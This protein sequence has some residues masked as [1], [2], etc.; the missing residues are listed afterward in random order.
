MQIIISSSLLMTAFMG[1]EIETEIEFGPDLGQNYGTI[2]EARDDSG[3]LRIGAGFV[4]VYNTRYRSDRQTLQF[5]VRPAANDP[6]EIFE[7]D[8]LPRPSEAAGSYLFDF[9]GKLHSR[10]YIADSAMRVWDPATQTWGID[11]D[12][13]KPNEDRGDQKMTVAG[14]MLWFDS[15]SVKYDGEEILVPPEVGQYYNFYYGNGHLAWFHTHKIENGGFT[16]LYAVAWNPAGDRQVDVARAVVHDLAIVGETPF[17]WGQFGEQLIT[18]SNWGGVYVF[19]GGTWKTALPVKQS[20]S[21]QVYSMLNF[22]DEMLF[23]EYPSGHLWVWDGEQITERKGWPPIMPGV[24]DY[25]REAQTTVIYRGELFVGVWPWAELWRYDVD[26]KSWQFV[27]R[28]FSKPDISDEVGH[29]W[30]A[31]IKK[32]NAEQ[33]TNIVFNNWG[34]RVTGL[35]PMGD[36]MYL[37]TSAKAP[38]GREK[39]DWLTDD[40]WEEYGRPYRVRLPGNLSVRM[41]WKT[42]P[43]KLIFQ[44]DEGIMKIYQ[45]GKLLGEAKA[46]DDTPELEKQGLSELKLTW[47]KGIFG[48]AKMKIGQ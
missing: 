31:E 8:P 43:T 15:G 29:P 44:I 30:E 34:Q 19:E 7:V 12:F 24:S 6:D 41:N 48:P 32:Y 47:G 36:A 13:T 14:K 26:E 1:I 35:I 40:V 20:G 39:Y 17:S 11:D 28:M 9:E 5:F 10:S 2:F 27:R 23:A 21:R 42:G 37:S 18:V 3:R 46:P 33:G 25:A 38:W 45:D 22:G 4:G 16:K